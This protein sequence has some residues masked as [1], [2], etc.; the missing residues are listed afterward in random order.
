LGQDQADKI[1]EILER[2]LHQDR[3]LDIIPIHPSSSDTRTFLGEHFS[4]NPRK[5]AETVKAGYKA[6]MSTLAQYEF[7]D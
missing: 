3:N 5:L 2:E 7:E 6:G 1:M 4:L